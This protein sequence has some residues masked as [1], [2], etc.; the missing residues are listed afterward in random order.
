MAI[1]STKAY[2]SF[3]GIGAAIKLAKNPGDLRQDAMQ[4]VKAAFTGTARADSLEVQQ[5]RDLVLKTYGAFIDT[6][7]QCVDP[8]ITFVPALRKGGNGPQTSGMFVPDSSSGRAVT[9]PGKTGIAANATL[10]DNSTAPLRGA[11]AT[12]VQSGELRFT[13][14]NLYLPQ[15]AV[16]EYL[17]CFTNPNFRNAL[18]DTRLDDQLRHN[19]VEGTTQYLTLQTPFNRRGDSSGKYSGIYKE[20]VAFIGKVAD[21]VGIETLKKAYLAG[22]QKAIGKMWDA[23][24]KRA[25]ILF[26]R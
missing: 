6:T 22:D 12:R 17:H 8:V 19:L 21:D 10:A 7:K 18:G 11:V 26:R 23:A 5:G 9:P 24:T 15:I 4:F 25:E 3:I 13:T 16:H 20:E 2:L 14:Y 1:T